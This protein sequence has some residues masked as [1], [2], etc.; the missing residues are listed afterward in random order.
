[1]AP[2]RETFVNPRG[3]EHFG[4]AP[5]M[6]HRGVT[7]ASRRSEEL[8]DERRVPASEGAV[9]RDAERGVLIL[10]VGPSGAG[11]DS[12][13]RAATRHFAHD[14]RFVF[15]R[16]VVTRAADHASEEIEAVTERDFA[17]R[18][19]EGRFALSWS[20]HGL[21]Y[22]LPRSVVERG[23]DQ[24]SCVVANASRATIDEARARFA[25][26]AVILVTASDAT[27]AKRLA[28]RRRESAAEIEQRIARAKA[29]AAGT[30]D[31]AIHNDGQLAEAVARFQA[32]L[33]AFADARP[34]GA[35]G[36]TARR[37]VSG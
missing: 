13:L 12:L 34:S 25:R 31:A 16:R 17:A 9:I 8:R 27:L 29:V 4:D 23:L 6:V 24:G 21:R 30:I 36:P 11:K 1:M 33:V 10:V 15:V 3:P 18:E 22:G 20:A 37:L 28:E 35:Q 7:A 32:A 14:D 19:L 26:V 2:Q 5:R